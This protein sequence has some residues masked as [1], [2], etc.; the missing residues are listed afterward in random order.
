MASLVSLLGVTFTTA[1]HV[2]HYI[3]AVSLEKSSKGFETL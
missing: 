2:D 3:G 1:F